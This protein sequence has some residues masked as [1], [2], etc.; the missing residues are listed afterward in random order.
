MRS[1]ANM[2]V[3]RVE[4]SRGQV[5]CKLPGTYRLDRLTDET[6]LSLTDR[7]LQDDFV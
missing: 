7:F 1:R 6:L 2:D 3:V 4:R 5:N